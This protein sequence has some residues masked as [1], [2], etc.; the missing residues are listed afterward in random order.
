MLDLLFVFII[1]TFFA[2]SVAMIWGIERL[3]E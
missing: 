3:R 1:F 2:L